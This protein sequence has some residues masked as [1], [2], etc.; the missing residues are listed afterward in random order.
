MKVLK[1]RFYRIVGCPKATETDRS[2]NN[3]VEADVYY[4]KGGMSWFS[5]KVIPR[6]YYMSTSIMGRF[7]SGGVAMES[8][9][10]GG[11]G[12]KQTIKEV[13]RQ[14]AKASREAIEYYEKNIDKYVKDAFSDL[15][16]EFEEEI[17]GGELYG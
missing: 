6:G 3:Y 7:T 14:T 4:D 15:E 2:Y 8:H 1:R 5:Y 9:T 16:L 11:R 13:S 12:Y 10:L 17:D